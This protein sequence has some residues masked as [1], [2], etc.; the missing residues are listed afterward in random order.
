M[1]QLDRESAL[2]KAEEFLASESKEW[3]HKDIKIIH[4]KAF[5][6]EGR[7]IAP[8]NTVSYLNTGKMEHG[9]VGN[10]P[11]E[12]DMETGECE[13]IDIMKVLDYRDMGY[14]I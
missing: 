10:V 6:H 12:V 11:I 3:K 2:A 13:F 7:L 1:S 5:Q 8:Y 9:L 4:D 14:P